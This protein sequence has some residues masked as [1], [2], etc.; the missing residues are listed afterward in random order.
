MPLARLDVAVARLGRVGENAEGNDVVP[1]GKFRASLDQP[2]ES[3]YIADYMVGRQHEH[4]GVATREAGVF[5]QK[6]QCRKSQRRGSVAPCRFKCD[7]QRIFS[8][9]PHMFSDEEAV[10]LIAQHQRRRYFFYAVQ[11]SD[12]ILKE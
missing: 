9:L 5:V 10:F 2:A 12:R 7:C 8:E 3:L 6:H 11:P 1:G 4:Y